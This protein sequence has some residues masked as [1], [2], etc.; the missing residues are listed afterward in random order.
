[1]PIWP[2]HRS[3]AETDA[4]ALLSA[5]TNASRRPEFYGADR[6]PDTLD[7]RFELMAVN[8]VLAM[9]RLQAD[10]ALK[11]LAQAFADRLFSQFDAGLR[12]AGTGD[13]AV[14]KRMHKLAG[15]FYGRLD[16][17]AGALAEPAALE[18][19]L[20]RNVWRL[21]SHP[22]ASQLASYVA[23]AAAEQARAP[24]SAMFTAEGW[25]AL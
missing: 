8:G 3:R 25:P 19:A 5:V 6:A 21:E 22:F 13:T 4:E 23:K 9:L 16:S 14:P 1:M 11:P 24:I 20:A 18:A 17:Y 12:E 2:F 15:D 10:P 7:G